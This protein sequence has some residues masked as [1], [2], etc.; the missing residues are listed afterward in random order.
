[1]VIIYTQQ[2]LLAERPV[3]ESAKTGIIECKMSAII[4]LVIIFFNGYSPKKNLRVKTASSVKNADRI[5]SLK[6]NRIS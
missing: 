4:H 1:M 3:I 2:N 6:A 5:Y